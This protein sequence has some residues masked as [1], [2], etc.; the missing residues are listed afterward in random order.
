LFSRIG[1]YVSDFKGSAALKGFQQLK[2][3]Y[4]GGLGFVGFCPV[5]ADIHI[6]ENCPSRRKESAGAA[7]HTG[8]FRTKKVYYRQ[9]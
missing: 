4:A 8:N 2:K 7:G 3:V 1:Y 9:K 5:T 6:R